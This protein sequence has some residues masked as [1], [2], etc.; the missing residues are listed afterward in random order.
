MAANFAVFIYFE[1]YNLQYLVK[2]STDFN[3]IWHTSST[4]S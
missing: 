3:E 1:Y 4:Y 2:Y